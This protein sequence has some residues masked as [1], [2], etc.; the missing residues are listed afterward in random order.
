MRGPS[1][2][3][4][5]DEARR[6]VDQA[7]RRLA[8][9][10]SATV[11]A[12]A[13][14]TGSG[15]SS[16]FNA[17]SGTDLAT[18][19]VRRPTT[20]HAMA[21]SWGDESAEDLLDWLKIPRRHALETDPTMTAALDGLVLL[22]LPDHDSTEVE[23]RMEVDRLVQLVDMLIWVVD[24]QKYADAALHDRYLMPLA[25][26]AEVMMIIL[27][28]ADRL[29]AAQREQC[30]RGSATAAGLG[31]PGQGAGLRDLG[32]DR[33]GY[34]R[35]PRHAGPAGRRETGSRTPVGGRRL[36]RRGQAQRVIRHH[37]V[38]SAL[39]VERQPADHAGRAGGGGPGGDGGGR[40]G[41]AAAWRL[42]H[43]LAGAGLGGQVQARPATPAASGSAR[44]RPTAQGDRSVASRA[45]V[46]AGD[47]GCA[48]G[49]GGHRACELSPTRLLRVSRAAG[50]T[51]SSARRGRP[52]T[53][54]RTASIVR[55]RPPIL[56]LP[57]TGGGG[58]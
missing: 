12:L 32:R 58:S 55:S 18:V 19:G 42:G 38:D 39:P 10:G 17:L 22:D 54:C 37:Q 28:Q 7:D 52:R 25:Q 31:G 47:F 8:L 43:R 51:R 36:G 13:G 34:R 4:A 50:P 23:H 24:P 9:S 27:N 6:V 29:T 49:P 26:H 15:K 57:G 41:L 35:A 30:L 16:I 56:I 46:V 44:R 2:S 3:G 20:A 11:V 53:R 33:R 40:Q 45:Y 14:A 48:E 21:A 1:R 5:L